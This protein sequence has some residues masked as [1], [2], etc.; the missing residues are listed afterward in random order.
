MTKQIDQCLSIKA[1]QRL[2]MEECAVSDLAKE[3][4]TPLYAISESQLRYNARSFQQAFGS[5]W[6]E[7]NVCIMPAIKANYTL[8]LR[9]ILTEEGCGCDLFSEGELWAALEAGVDPAKTSLNGN[10]K[11]GFDN[12][13]LKT[14]IEHGVRITMDDASEFPLIEAVAKSLGKKAIVRIRLRPEYPNLNKPTDFLVETIPT[15]LATQVYKSGMPMEDVIPLGK[16]VLASKH[17]KLTGIHIHQG[18]H[19]RELDFWQGTM[20]GLAKALGQLKQAWNGWQPQEIDLGG[21]FP[22]PRDPTGREVDRSAWFTTRLLSSAMKIGNLFNARNKVAE[23]LMDVMVQKTLL[24]Q[25]L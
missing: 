14:A 20:Q 4:G 2:Y 23:S 3:F 19:S 15:E 17:V 10:S 9:Y 22:P 7:G 5:R 12:N 13:I 11:V 24:A 25:I 16:K 6:P 1:D 8:A 21:G 18:R